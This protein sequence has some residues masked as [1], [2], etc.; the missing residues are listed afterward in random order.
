MCRRQEREN[1]A[2]V[3]RDLADEVDRIAGMDRGD[4]ANVEEQAGARMMRRKI[5]K[6]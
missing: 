3:D 1:Q 2:A 6:R 5:G 4:R